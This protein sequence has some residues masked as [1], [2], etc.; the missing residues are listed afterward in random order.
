MGAGFLI[1]I[2]GERAGVALSRPGQQGMRLLA[3]TA[4]L[5]AKLSARLLLTC[6][7]PRS[8]GQHPPPAAPLPLSC[9]AGEMMV[10]RQWRP[11][12]GLLRSACTSGG[13]CMHAVLW[14]ALARHA[15]QGG[16]HAGPMSALGK[17]D[18]PCTPA[19]DSRPAHPPRVLRGKPPACLAPSRQVDTSGAGEARKQSVGSIVGSS[20]RGVGHEELSKLSL[21]PV[22]SPQIDVDP[23][24]GRIVGLS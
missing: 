15:S 9:P 5:S 1:P 16:A 8:T 10:S 18:A 2:C 21:P 17:E 24:T 23:E 11:G 3:F 4:W 12:A 13:F 7:A 14:L 6:S 19:D 22:L 20:K